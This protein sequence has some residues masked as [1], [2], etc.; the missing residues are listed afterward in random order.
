MMDFLSWISAQKTCKKKNLSGKK[1]AFCQLFFFKYLLIYKLCVCFFLS[2]QYT[3]LKK[4]ALHQWCAE[5]KFWTHH[6]CPFLKDFAF[7]PQ[8]VVY[9]YIFSRKIVKFLPC[10]SN[11]RNKTELMHNRNKIDVMHCSSQLNLFL[12]DFWK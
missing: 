5:G 8:N 2:T 12:K 7:L 11:W 1:K 6:R 9:S 4:R 10:L 3:L